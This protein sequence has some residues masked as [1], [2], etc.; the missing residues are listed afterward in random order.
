MDKDYIKHPIILKAKDLADA[1]KNSK[2]FSDENK[3]IEII[4]E[5]NQIISSITGLNY[6]AICKPKSS[7]CG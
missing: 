7:C 6:S 1:I 5:C 3:K 4:I 2:E